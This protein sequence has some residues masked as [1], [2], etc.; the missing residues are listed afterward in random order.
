M[1]TT[2][3][4]SSAETQNIKKE[5]TEKNI[6]NHQTKT[7]DRNARKKKQWNYRTTRKEKIKCQY[8]VLIYQ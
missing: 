3:Q 4:N 1:I 5:K 6:E 2:K 8:Q 7:A